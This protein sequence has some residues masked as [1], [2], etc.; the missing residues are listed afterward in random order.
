MKIRNLPKSS[1]RFERLIRRNG[2][3]QLLILPRWLKHSRRDRLKM[4]KSLERTRRRC[5]SMMKMAIL[6]S[7]LRS[8]WNSGKRTSA[9]ILKVGFIGRF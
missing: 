2:N 7:K 5:L 4:K 8:A 9:K 1:R 6:N 3:D